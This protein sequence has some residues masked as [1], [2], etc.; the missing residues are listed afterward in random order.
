MVTTTGARAGAASAGRAAAMTATVRR[1]VAE[2]FTRARLARGVRDQAVALQPLQEPAPSSLRQQRSQK[3]VGP[4]L[5]GR[6]GVIE[7]LRGIGV[8]FF[9][10]G[11]SAGG[12]DSSVAFCCSP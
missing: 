2:R 11:T 3:R 5:A 10:R 7:R 4:A 12:N 6:T 9:L 1:R 8:V